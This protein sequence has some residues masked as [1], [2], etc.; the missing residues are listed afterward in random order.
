MN[1][2]WTE[3][4]LNKLSSIK[5]DRFSKEETAEHKEK[6]VIEIEEKVIR[7][8]TLFPSRNYKN[9]YYVK[10][11]PYIVS[12]KFHPEKDIYSIIALQHEK[13]NKNY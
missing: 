3:T 10:I 4:A 6:L 11:K 13:Q 7:L 2:Q 1:V 8:G 12:Y 9:R 5:S